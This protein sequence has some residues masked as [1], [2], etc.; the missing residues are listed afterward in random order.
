MFYET[1]WWHVGNLTFGY[2]FIT[3][4]LSQK[5]ST[6][7][8]FAYLLQTYNTKSLGCARLH[9]NTLSN[10]KYEDEDTSKGQGVVS[11]KVHFLI[12]VDCTSIIF[13]T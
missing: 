3:N 7:N 1:N 8:M 13:L 2:L 11:H 4:L 6:T 5:D 9:A 10:F 12:C